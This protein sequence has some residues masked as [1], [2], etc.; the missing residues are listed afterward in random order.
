MNR[1]LRELLWKLERNRA[2]TGQFSTAQEYVE[3]SLEEALK[4]IDR[5]PGKEIKGF[6]D[7]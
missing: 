4:W 3:F 1:K 2:F 7:F 5:Y 6:V